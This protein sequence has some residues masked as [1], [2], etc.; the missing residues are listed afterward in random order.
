MY[1]CNFYTW[2]SESLISCA[3]AAPWRCQTRCDGSTVCYGEQS[4]P[5]I[6]PPSICIGRLMPPCAGPATIYTPPYCPSPCPNPCPYPPPCPCPYPP[7]CPEPSPCPCP[8]PIYPPCPEPCPCPIYPP[9]PPPPPPCPCP[10]TPS[11]PCP[12]GPLY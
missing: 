2:R 1:N 6:N 7:P 8:I 3:A 5:T 9:C 4:Q 11:C 12:L 10:Y